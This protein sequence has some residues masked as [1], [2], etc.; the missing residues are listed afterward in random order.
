MTDIA[1]LAKLEAA[2]EGSRELDFEVARCVDLWRRAKVPVSGRHP[3]YWGYWRKRGGKWWRTQLPAYTTSI[4]AAL[5]LVPD[6]VA[7]EISVPRKGG[8]Y[9]ILAGVS[10]VP[11]CS[12]GET[13]SL[14]I[15]IAALR[16]RQAKE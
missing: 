10:P 1:V 6:G 8:G 11:N 3:A 2:K 12:F 14:A 15:C 4:D 7:W 16:A 13:P 9:R 5:T